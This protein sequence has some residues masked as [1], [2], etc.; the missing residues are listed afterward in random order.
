M[1]TP[2]FSSC[3]ASL[4]SSLALGGFSHLKW[5][6]RSSDVTQYAS[7]KFPFHNAEDSP[8][9]STIHALTSH[10]SDDH[11]VR[12][13]EEHL[14]KGGWQLNPGYISPFNELVALL[15]DKRREAI[16]NVTRDRG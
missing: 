9:S 3:Y 14:I 6:Y 1:V 7:L 15:Q 16:M 8:L 11:V 13:R 4:S 10:F 12:I 5:H 2:S